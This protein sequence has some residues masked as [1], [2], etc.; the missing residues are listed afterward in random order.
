[1]YQKGRSAK[2]AVDSRPWKRLIENWEGARSPNLCA[3]L[4]LQL[5]FYLFGGRQ[6]LTYRSF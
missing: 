1:M 5:K 3:Q 2:I 4:G 6:G